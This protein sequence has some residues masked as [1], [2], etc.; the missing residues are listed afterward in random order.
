MEILMETYTIDISGKP[1]Q[2]N[3]AGTMTLFAYPPFIKTL[4]KIKADMMKVAD[5]PDK[6]S[7]QA[8]TVKKTIIGAGRIMVSI[9]SLFP[10]QNVNVTLP[11][12]QDMRDLIPL[13]DSVLECTGGNKSDCSGITQLW[14]DSMTRQLRI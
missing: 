13:I 14:R 3:P 4:D 11:L 10:A 8:G 1:S 5:K 9:K 2:F 6:L 12:I 7:L